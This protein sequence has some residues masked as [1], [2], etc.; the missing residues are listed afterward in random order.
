MMK[1]ALIVPAALLAAGTMLSGQRQEVNPQMA[2]PAQPGLEAEAAPELTPEEMQTIIDRMVAL[3]AAEPVPFGQ[4]AAPQL[5]MMDAEAVA[6]RLPRRLPSIQPGIAGVPDDAPLNHQLVTQWGAA[7]GKELPLVADNYLVQALQHGAKAVV[8]TMYNGNGG[9]S[10]LSNSLLM[11]QPVFSP[12]TK[13]NTFWIMLAFDH[14]NSRLWQTTL[15]D[16]HLE[17]GNYWTSDGEAE[18]YWERI[19]FDQC[20]GQAIQWVYSHPA[21]K[22]YFQTAT[23][24]NVEGVTNP[25]SPQDARWLRNAE[26]HKTE[27]LVVSQ[28][29][30]SQCT[31]YALSERA[32]STFS[33]FEAINKNGPWYHYVIMDGNYSE[34]SYAWTD[35][36]GQKRDCSGWFMAHAKL[37]VTIRHNTVMY[38]HGDR[39]VVQIWGCGDGIPGTPDVVIDENI[40][41]SDQVIDI[42]LRDKTDTV[43]I[44]RNQAYG[45]TRVIISDWTQPW[46]SWHTSPNWDEKAVIAEFPLHMASYQYGSV[47]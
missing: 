41:L 46:Y 42:R 1:L 45:G 11:G 3:D 18:C 21:S 47:R 37:G 6:P 5:M 4:S 44:R 40:F 8:N 16:A 14:S 28:S 15:Q 22:R 17:H 12:A 35:P 33:W 38:R 19:R 9:P 13:N 29:E 30:T 25:P 27:K 26:A 23:T 31:I 24:D 34:T 7:W 32:G 39:D 36:N 43:I 10:Y 20:R 2:P